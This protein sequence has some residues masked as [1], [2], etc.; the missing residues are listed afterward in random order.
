MML[1]VDDPADTWSPGVRFTAATVPS[2]GLTIVAWARFCSAEVTSACAASTAAWSA[3]SSADDGDDGA[4]EL[5]ALLAAVDGVLVD[6]FDDD[7]ELS[8]LSR[9][10][11]ACAT[12]ACAPETC[13]WAARDFCNASR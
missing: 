10:S 11:S 12:A 8:K 1:A 2:I 9:S 6:P 3:T 4:E 7:A 13:C 5:L